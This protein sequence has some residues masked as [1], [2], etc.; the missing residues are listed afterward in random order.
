MSRDS[1]KP[2][3]LGILARSWIGLSGVVTT[4]FVTRYLPP[5]LQGYHYT[6]FSLLSFQP[7]VE[8]GFG[9]VL[10]QFV[11]H[12]MAFIRL[13]NGTLRGD[14]DK[15]QRLASLVRLG[16]WWYLAVS[17]V[18]LLFIATVG[19]LIFTHHATDVD[20]KGPWLVL[21]VCS[22]FYLF[23]TFLRCLVEGS[24]RVT[25]TQFVAVVSG[26]VGSVAAWYGLVSG[27]NLYC[28][29][30]QYAT[31][32]LIAYGIYIP[33]TLPFIRLLRTRLPAF[34]RLSWRS[35]FWPQQWRIGLSWFSGFIMFQSFVPIAF[36]FMGPQQA[37]RLG[38]TLQIYSGVNSIASV[39][40]AV[41]QPTMGIMCARYAF[42]ELRQLVRRTIELGLATA[43]SL[44]IACYVAISALLRI[45][46][47]FYARISD[48]ITLVAFLLAAVCLQI[49]NVQT[50]AVRFQKR[51]PFLINSIVGAGA[52][53]C[54]NVIT[55]AYFDLPAMGITF[56]LIMVGVLIPWIHRL[57]GRH[58]PD[59]TGEFVA[60]GGVLEE[61]SKP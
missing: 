22:A 47:Q 45:Q 32:A 7:V 25:V 56:L 12:E 44:S 8:L 43:I 26:F 20:W 18:F 50:A 55:A 48:R 21:S 5:G 2:A 42:A 38:L 13:E 49:P 14:V 58:Q 30:I 11:T 9:T 28:L 51:E 1:L 23:T 6:F 41:V 40:L 4:F 10:L 53:C 15:V 39:W 24:N 34:S 35:E 52:V 54:A 46:P 36:F 16:L 19:C 59:I 27:W 57:Y 31:M 60:S 3:L 61:C 17:A 37:G 33:V 29:A